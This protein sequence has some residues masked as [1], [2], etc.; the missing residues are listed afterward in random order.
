MQRFRKHLQDLRD[1]L[2]NQRMG[3]RQPMRWSLDG[4]HCL[5]QVRCAM[6]DGRLEALFREWYPKFRLTPAAV[7]LPAL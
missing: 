7:E 1:Y 4:A 3:K 5:L 2:V 6:L